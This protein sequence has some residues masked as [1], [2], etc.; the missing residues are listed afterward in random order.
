M[1]LN[2]LRSVRGA[3]KEDS[4]VDAAQLWDYLQDK[5]HLLKILQGKQEN[6]VMLLFID[7]E[8]TEEFKRTW[9]AINIVSDNSFKIPLKKLKR[10]GEFEKEIAKLV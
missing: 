7:S 8:E 9:R 4:P 3:L 10:F 5:R 2:D 1:Q 6:S